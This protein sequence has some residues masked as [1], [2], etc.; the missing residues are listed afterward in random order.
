[1]GY[2]LLMVVSAIGSALAAYIVWGLAHNAVVIYLFALLFG[3]VVSEDS[4]ISNICL[5]SQSVNLEWS[6]Q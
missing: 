5:N 2:N 1:M 4:Y 6:I 3:G